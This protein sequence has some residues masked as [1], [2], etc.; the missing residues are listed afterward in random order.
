M[1]VKPFI[2]SLSERLLLTGKTKGVC[3][4]GGGGGGMFG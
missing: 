4:G 1:H 2:V 3:G